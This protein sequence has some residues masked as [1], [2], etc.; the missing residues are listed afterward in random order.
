MRNISF[1][2][3]KQRLRNGLVAA[4]FLVAQVGAVTVPLLH[5]T[6]VH[7]AGVITSNNHQ[8]QN[9][10]G[11]WTSGNTTLYSEG[12]FVN[13]RYTL[14]SSQAASGAMLIKYSNAAPGCTQFFTNYFALKSVTPS[15]IATVTTSGSP[16]TVVSGGS[17]DWQQTLNLNFTTAG[18]VTVE[19]TLQYSGT[20]GDCSGSSTHT[21]LGEA[22]NP[23]QYS[24]TGAQTIPLP[25]SAI[26]LAPSLT[27]TK[28]VV[29]GTALPSD[30]T[31]TVSPA[32]NGQTTL[33]IPIG[34]NSVTVSNINPAGTFV[35]TEHGP[36]GY[37]F[38]SGTGTNCSVTSSGVMTA[39]T[40]PGRPTSTDAVCNFTNSQTTGSLELRKA[41]VGTP[42]QT[43][44]KI[45]TTV[46]GSEVDSQQTG[47]AGAAPLTTGQSSVA[48]GTYYMSESALA[49]YTASIACFNDANNNGTNDSE[50][51]VSL[52][53]NNSVVLGS[54]QHIIC[55][56][57]NTRDTGSVRVNKL[58]DTTGT[59][60]FVAPTSPTTFTWSLDGTGSHAMG[61][62]GTVTG[63][64]TGPHDVDENTPPTDYH[65]VGWFYTSDTTKS[66]TS[67][68]NTTRP[69]G[70]SV[71][72]DVTTEIT[73]CNARDTGTVS[74][75][76]TVQGGDASPSLWL[77]TVSD[78]S[79]TTANSGD[80]RTI[81]TG[82]YT[83]TE[84]NGPTGY[85]A[86]GATGICSFLK[87][88]ISLTVTTSGGQCEVQNT[89]DT[90]SIKVVKDVVNDNG[91][92]KTYADFSFT[93]DGTNYSFNPTTSPDGERTV[94]LPTGTYSVVEPEADT[95]GYATS[96]DNCTNITVVKGQTQTC[97][98]T[99]NDKPGKLTVNKVVENGVYGT[100]EASDFSF[101]LNGD[102]TN[103]RFVNGN[104][105]T[106]EGSVT[107]ELNAGSYTATENE[108]FGYDSN[109][110]DCKNVVVTNGGEASCTITNTAQRKV[111]I[112]HRTDSNKNPY[113][114]ISVPISAID[115]VS[116]NQAND[117]NGDHFS[118]HTGPIWYPGIDGE[119]GD[120][121][122]PL[123]GIH[124]GLNWDDYGQA[125][126]NND[127]NP[128]AQIVV[129]KYN[130]LNRN[131]MQDEGEPTLSGWDMTLGC[132]TLELQRFLDV[133]LDQSCASKTQTTGTD[134]TTTFVNVNTNL[135]YTLN[136]TIP[137]NSNWNL[138]NI[139]C[140]EEQGSLDGDTFYFNSVGLGETVHCYVGNYQ[141]TG[142][143]TVVKKL[144]P[145]TDQGK[146]NLN[147][148]GKTY[149][150][151]VGDSGSTGAQTFV[152]GE[153]TVSETAGTNTS[154]ND[155]ESSYNCV[156][157]RGGTIASGT[158][159][160][161]KVTLSED[162][163]NIVCTFTNNK[164]EILGATAPLV[165]T[166]SNILATTIASL[167]L[168]STVAGLA[169]ATR[170]QTS[171]K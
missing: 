129:T 37:V 98:I 121:I 54:D 167:M 83:V 14:T 139:D 4:L 115:G 160:S 85:S 152:T 25:G 28:T 100:A 116:G 140:G 16:V 94:T 88:I 105:T 147:I 101:K 133:A 119:W 19:Y 125:T 95:M 90:G 84:S 17:S 8:G 134:G 161:A 158:G 148:N 132:Q 112:C 154:L 45:G 156:T 57:T 22:A 162:G 23:G 137:E 49:D 31:F 106:T 79:G 102:D 74:F 157:A 109:D 114:R 48:T 27:V 82:T 5:A 15:G 166:G 127:C 78:P 64:E 75:L 38:S 51:T 50:A 67:G 130:D 170:R 2:K 61:S 3:L 110:S 62:T 146:F 150:A 122:P 10:D 52:G 169:F 163:Q 46:G 55:T 131:G 70:L 144:T 87:G 89:R 118:E 97:T 39:T 65:F 138:S 6:P 155:Y 93:V 47:A 63:V 59:G 81:Q 86:T 171:S 80:S 1:A 141:N 30:F 18:T 35:I 36:A 40:A 33:S 149:A 117:P 71:T 72:K 120:I 20:A 44:L 32:I 68:F 11:T 43:T 103:Y 56:F 113:V 12:D 124:D 34:Q 24:N 41:W 142:T 58:V 151:N 136:E 168:I 108:A 60:T 69:A 7:A 111:V 123:E 66:C 165:N 42:S 13:F 143:I 91:G 104:E 107:V 159:T 21:A 164:G 135:D 53:L 73:I 29:G 145:S 153:Y 76:K 92:S 128:P 77:F 26:L 96:Y 99:N 9:S 126:Y